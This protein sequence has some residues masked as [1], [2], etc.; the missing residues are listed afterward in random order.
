M[1]TA[2]TSAMTPADTRPG[3]MTGDAARLHELV[4]GPDGLSPGQVDALLAGWD[5]AKSTVVEF[6]VA[7]G[8]LDRTGAQTLGAVLKGYVLLRGAELC[9]LFKRLPRAAGSSP[10]RDSPHSAPNAPAASAFAASTSREGSRPDPIV[11]AEARYTPDGVTPVA[12]SPIPDAPDASEFARLPLRAQIRAL[13]AG[14]ATGR[15]RDKAALHPSEPGDHFVHYTLLRRIGESAHALVFQARHEHGQRT[16]ALKLPRSS[17]APASLPRF[18]AQAQIHA[19]LAHAG[20][21]PLIDSGGRDGP[22]YL[23][24]ADMGAVNIAAYLRRF[25]RCV[26]AW[27]LAQLFVDVAQVLGAA[28]KVG[29]FHGDLM[30]ANILMCEHDAR[31]RLTDFGMRVP[32]APPGLFTAPELAAGG[33]HGHATIQAD[34]YSLGVALQHVAIG[35]AGPVT[36]LQQHRPDLPAALV[37]AIDRLTARSP[38]DRPGSWEEAI[39]AV[40]VACPRIAGLRQT[41]QHM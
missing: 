35:Q 25:T 1:I 39:A 24:Y 34:M 18:T 20:V 41:S 9:R 13:R 37:A 38:L 36:A 32:G 30:L 23:A 19:R 12:V 2:Q 14:L 26:Q 31:V 6:L 40:F 22:P 15:S 33:R 28:A 5:P 8:V 16:V 27:T 21:L 11:V 10:P 29:I 3:A 4:V 17:A 7:R